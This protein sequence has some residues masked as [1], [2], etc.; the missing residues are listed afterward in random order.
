MVKNPSST[1]KIIDYIFDIYN[2][3]PLIVRPYFSLIITE[4]CPKQPIA[5]ASKTG[6]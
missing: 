1:H 5:K 3:I 6:P 2:K 4:K